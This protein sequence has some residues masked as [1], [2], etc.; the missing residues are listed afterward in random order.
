MSETI[1]DGRQTTEL[2]LAMAA[3]AIGAVALVAGLVLVVIG[4]REPWA[5]V[6]AIGGSL[7][8]AASSVGYSLSRGRVKAAA[9]STIV[10]GSQR[11][12]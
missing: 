9:A 11:V 12:V 1:K 7:S 2:A 5:G 8:S 4:G 10:V 3:T 6:L